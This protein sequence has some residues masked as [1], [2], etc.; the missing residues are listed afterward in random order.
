LREK[1]HVA[2]RRAIA[3]GDLP[4][5]T[6]MVCERCQ[7]AQAAHWH[8]DMGYAEEYHLHVIALCKSCHGKA[9]WLDIGESNRTS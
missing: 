7:E 6:A 8:H 3:R 4:P 5:A 9:H 1:A 2:V